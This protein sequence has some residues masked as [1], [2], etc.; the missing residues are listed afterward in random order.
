M[1]AGTAEG[2]HLNPQRGGRKGQ[3]GKGM[4]I[5][6]PQSLPQQHNSSSKATPPNSHS[7]WASG[8]HFYSNHNTMKVINILLLLSRFYSLIL[9]EEVHAEVKGQPT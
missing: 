6:K 5:L 8:D 9:G 7:L 2:L 3:T 4:N 1:A